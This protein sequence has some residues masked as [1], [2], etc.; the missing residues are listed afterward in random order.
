MAA[1]ELI[2][3]GSRPSKASRI[4]ER[5]AGPWLFQPAISALGTCVAVDAGQG[6][7]GGGLQRA[8]RLRAPAAPRARRCR[9]R[10]GSR[11]GPAAARSS[12]RRSSGAC[13]S[14]TWRGQ[15][16][17]SWPAR[18]RR[19]TS[20]TTVSRRASAS[21][22]PAKAVNCQSAYLPP[23]GPANPR[24]RHAQRAIVFECAGQADKLLEQFG[25]RLWLRFG[26]EHRGQDLCKILRRHRS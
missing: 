10:G 23:I 11:R 15:S 3:P 7:D 12:S 4:S 17:I 5:S 1:S 2:D 26:V 16:R 24:E 20:P 14:A 25:G 9:R 22:K 8:A 21:S 19:R 18:P 13:S 6:F